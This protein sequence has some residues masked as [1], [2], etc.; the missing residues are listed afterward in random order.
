MLFLFVFFTTFKLE[1]N[2]EPSS[3]RISYYPS[4]NFAKVTAT[5]LYQLLNAISV[6]SL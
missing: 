5:K 4:M 2:T 1:E 3:G 6:P